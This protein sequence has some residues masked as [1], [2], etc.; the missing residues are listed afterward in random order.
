MRL[1]RIIAREWLIF[2]LVFFLSPTVLALYKWVR[3]QEIPSH[4]PD[5][6]PRLYDL[7]VTA[8]GYETQLLVD[9]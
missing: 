9:P 8:P 2:L 6:R 5:D 4:V 7:L 3:A 1:K